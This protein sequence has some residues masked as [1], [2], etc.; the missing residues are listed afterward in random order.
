MP[1]MHLFAATMRFTACSF[2]VAF[3]NHYKFT[4]KERDAESNLDEFGARHYASPLGRFMT[5]DWAEKPIDVPYANFG[6]PQ[7][8]NLYG[9]VNNNPTTT[10][11]PDGHCPDGCPLPSQV[12]QTLADLDQQNQANQDFYEGALKGVVNFATSSMN[13]F[14]TMGESTE[15]PIPQ[16]QPANE[17]QAIGMTAGALGLG[18]ASLA[19]D[20]PAA[21][22]IEQNAAKGP[23][24]ESRVLNS[25]GETKNTQAVATPEGRSIPDF[26]NSRVVGEIKDAKSVSNTRQL[27]IQKEAAQQSKREHQLITGKKTQVTNNAAQGT[28]VIRRKDL[29]PQ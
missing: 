18:V 29:G 5:P 17:I 11:D 7:S 26:Q 24:S 15:G 3:W 22:T 1:T 6:N 13:A 12:P 14:I 2:S 25:I 19:A 27:R 28:K 16:I 4:G 20:A 9:Y 10:A 23:A 8:L 21:S